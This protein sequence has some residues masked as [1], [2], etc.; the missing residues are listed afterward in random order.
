LNTI[1]AIADSL[2]A[3][4]ARFAAPALQ[5]SSLYIIVTIVFLALTVVYQKR[6]RP[7]V[8]RV[9]DFKPI[10][11][12]RYP[13]RFRIAAKIVLLGATIAM[14][15]AFQRFLL[16]THPLPEIIAGELV[17]GTN[18]APIVDARARLLANDG[19]EIAIAT[20]PSD[21]AGFYTIVAH[22]PVSRTARIEVGWAEC[23]SV[24]TLTLA[25]AYEIRR[26]SLGIPVFRH[27]VSCS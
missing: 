18:G 22:Q 20:A 27:Y 15:M 13:H 26:T 17:D 1:I 3:L 23:A 14:P 24:K 9:G 10:I 25:P 8:F 19:G 2:L 6:E 7:D 4:T 5:A 21:A 12:Y 16:A 11:E